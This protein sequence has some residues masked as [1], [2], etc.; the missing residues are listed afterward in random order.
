MAGGHVLRGGRGELRSAGQ[1]RAPFGFAQG[2]L[3][4]DTNICRASLGRAGEGTRPYVC[5]TQHNFFGEFT[6]RCGVANALNGKG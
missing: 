1:A 2:G 3:W 4:L 5:G 6:E